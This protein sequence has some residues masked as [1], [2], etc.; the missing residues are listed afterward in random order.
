MKNDIR[1]SS[2]KRGFNAQTIAEE[3]LIQH[4]IRNDY[5]QNEGPINVYVCDD[6]GQWHFTSKG[7]INDLLQDFEVIQRIKKE[8]QA[9]FW[10]RNFR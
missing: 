2:G 10:E 4:H 7:E 3:A 5:Q 6:C 1:C 9:F 8:R